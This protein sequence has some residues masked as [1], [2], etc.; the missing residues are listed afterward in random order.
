[1]N[2]AR[3]HNL[4]KE[5]VNGETKMDQLPNSSYELSEERQAEYFSHV[6]A[7]MVSDMAYAVMNHGQQLDDLE[8]LA[9]LKKYGKLC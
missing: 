3:V 8:V 1:M 4:I 5:V 2:D 7:N 9:R 6:R